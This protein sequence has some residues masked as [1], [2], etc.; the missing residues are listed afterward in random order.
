MRLRL[1]DEIRPDQSRDVPDVK[2]L[3]FGQMLV[4]LAH[5]AVPLFVG[6]HRLQVILQAF[7]FGHVPGE[8]LLV[9]LDLRVPR[10][11]AGLVV[12]VGPA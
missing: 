11:D 3:A 1:L 10:V 9:T 5:D 7:D 8:V 6:A 4:D 2:H 12:R